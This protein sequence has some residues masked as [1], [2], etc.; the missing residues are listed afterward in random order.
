MIKSSPS[1][2]CY[3]KVGDFQKK[4]GIIYR[5]KQICHFT[6]FNSLF[7]FSRFFLLL[8]S[9]GLAW[10]SVKKQTKCNLKNSSLRYWF[11]IFLW[12]PLNFLKKGTFSKRQLMVKILS[13]TGGPPLTQKSLTRFPLP[14]F[15]ALENMNFTGGSSK[16]AQITKF[17]LV[18]FPP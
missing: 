11:G 15:L 7:E 4:I 9:V 16:L 1:I 2:W 13:I 3:I 18:I 8:M 17:D 6:F 14:R 5:L 12:A 10:K